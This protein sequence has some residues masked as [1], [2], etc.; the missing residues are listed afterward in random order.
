ML[1][2]LV[3]GILAIFAAIIGGFISYLFTRE[4]YRLEIQRLEIEIKGHDLEREKAQL[5]MEKLRLEIA[6]LRQQERKLLTDEFWKKFGAHIAQQLPADQRELEWPMLRDMFLELWQGGEGQI[7]SWIERISTT[8]RGRKLSN[9][10]VI[11][12]L[13][14]IEECDEEIKYRK[15]QLWE[16]YHF[17]PEVA[18]FAEYRLREKRIEHLS[19]KLKRLKDR[20]LRSSLGP[21]VNLSHADLHSVN[22]KGLD[23]GRALL[24]DANFGSAELQYVNFEDANLEGA[25]LGWAELGSANLQG[26]RLRRAS[27]FSANLRDANLEGADLSGA[28]LREADFTR[29]NLHRAI[30][31]G[32]RY[33]QKTRWPDG[34]DPEAAGGHVEEG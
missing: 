9:S 1:E 25:N 29:A 14:D 18:D 33:D 12:A 8:Y 13:V 26:T 22:L 5:E 15:N 27:L 32:A 30:L 7:E 4:K 23:L 17:R 2:P 16:Q 31:N 21:G 24:Q 28:D 19:R 3:T 34:F 11:D 20:I 10:E 6:N